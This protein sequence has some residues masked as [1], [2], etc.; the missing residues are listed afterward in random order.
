MYNKL[1]KNLN[2]KSKKNFLFNPEKLKLLISS[3][4]RSGRISDEELINNLKL[5]EQKLGRNP[6][7]D[8][9]TLENGSKYS[10]N[11]YK[12]FGSFAK[13][14]DAAGMS[15]NQV[16][17]ATKEEV[18][19]DLKNV[20]KKLNK[21]P[22]LE[23]YCEYGVIGWCA[24]SFTKHFGSF[25]DALLEADLILNSSHT[26]T[27]EKIKQEF[28]RW[29]NLN[30]KNLYCLSYNSIRNAK[31]DRLFSYCPETIK[32]KFNNISWKEIMHECGFKN[33]CLND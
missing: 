23:E 31:K 19:Q 21:T 13:A 27:T 12:R 1:I 30:N 16:R 4:K 24:A 8:D 33:Y 32:E 10:M 26:I 14:L 11:A 15:P 2:N 7:R 28:E 25:S 22:S 29:F 18:L 17:N 6:K 3:K 5:M 20:Y 9:M